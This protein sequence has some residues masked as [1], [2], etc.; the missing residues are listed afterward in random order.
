MISLKTKEVVKM[1][2]KA[3]RR[4]KKIERFLQ[5]EFKKAEHQV[6]RQ[7]PKLS[8]FVNNNPRDNKDAEMQGTPL[9]PVG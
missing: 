2:A 8:M 3:R 4:R 6:K 7:E 5:K 9:N 1:A